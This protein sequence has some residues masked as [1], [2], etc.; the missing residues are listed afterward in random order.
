MKITVKQLR[1]L[2]HEAMSL[3]ARDDSQQFNT[4]MKK[5]DSI[6]GDRLG[7]SLDDLPDMP[8]RDAFDNAISPLAFFN[9]TVQ[10]IVRDAG[11]L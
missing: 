7:V 11:M 8:F 1:G 5:L 3:G 2:I 10:K 6:C 9:K 4:W